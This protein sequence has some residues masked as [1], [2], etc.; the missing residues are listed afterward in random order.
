MK[1]TVRCR[2]RLFGGEIKVVSSMC[3]K[4]NASDSMK[5]VEMSVSGGV[6]WLISI[7]GS[8]FLAQPQHT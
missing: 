4:G 2:H 6:P 3:L 7:P 8:W 1:L 5:K